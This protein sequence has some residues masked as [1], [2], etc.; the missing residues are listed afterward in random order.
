MYNSYDLMSTMLLSDREHMNLPMGV[1]IQCYQHMLDYHYYNIWLSRP[2]QNLDLQT[3]LL[4]SDSSVVS[5][6]SQHP[7]ADKHNRY[8]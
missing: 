2:P 7:N 3:I 5:S 1:T 6:V 4:A 8:G